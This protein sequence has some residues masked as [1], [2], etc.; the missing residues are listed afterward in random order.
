MRKS[1]LPCAMSFC[2]AC[3]NKVRYVASFPS[4]LDDSA[5]APCTLTHTPTPKTALVKKEHRKHIKHKHVDKP[6]ALAVGSPVNTVSFANIR[7]SQSKAIANTD[8]LGSSQS[9][10]VALVHVSETVFPTSAY[11]SRPLLYAQNMCLPACGLYIY[12]CVC[13]CVCFAVDLWARVLV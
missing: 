11:F 7:P 8:I 10:H 12:I 2:M 6:T 3:A 4:A 9:Q 13:V 1:V 5:T